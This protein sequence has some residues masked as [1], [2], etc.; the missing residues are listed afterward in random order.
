MI[1]IGLDTY[2]VSANET[3]ISYSIA[4]LTCALD[5]TNSNAY[6]D[7]DIFY[8]NYCNSIQQLMRVYK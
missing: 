3:I 8:I 4:E 7:L 5:T 2:K 6:F 1:D